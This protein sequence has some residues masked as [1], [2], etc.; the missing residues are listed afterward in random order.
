MARLT[1]TNY[2]AQPFTYA[3]AATDLF[4]KEDVQVLAQAVDTHDHATGK[5]LPINVVSGIPAGSITSSM[6]ADGTIV[7]GDIADGAVTSAKILD[8]TIAT[9]DIADGAVTAAKLAPA[10][11]TSLATAQT[12]LLTNGGFEIWQ[13]GNGAFTTNHAADRWLV[14]G[15]GGATL[16]AVR[17]TTTVD[18]S[19]AACLAATIG[20]G[21]TLATPGNGVSLPAVY[22]TVYQKLEDH[23]QL[24]GRTLTF[25]VRMRG[26]ASSTAQL[27]FQHAIVDASPVLSVGTSYATYTFT[28]TIGTGATQLYATILFGSA[29]VYYLDNAMLVVGSQAADYVP[30][31]PADDLMRCQRYYEVINFANAQIIF[32]GVA[33][34]AAGPGPYVPWKVKKAVTPTMSSAA[35]QWIAQRCDTGAQQ[36]SGTQFNNVSADGFNLSA[37]TS[38]GAGIGFLFFANTSNGTITGEAN[39]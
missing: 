2:T 15:A 38:V 17:D 11:S 32:C 9:G 28:T 4:K 35:G 7:A 5:G 22:A 21:P 23:L 13:R 31:H 10:L 27:L 30:M 6:I 39:P 18:A 1:S 14:A 34:S 24:R 16:S 12:N 26:P 36:S 29:G 8:G 33:T 20:G 3:T 37:S 25:S 19:S